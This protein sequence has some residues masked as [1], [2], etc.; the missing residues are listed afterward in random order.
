LFANLFTPKP[1]SVSSL[2]G[3]ISL[4]IF[5]LQLATVWIL[6][7]API[8]SWFKSGQEGATPS[9]DTH[10]KCPDCRELILKDAKKCKHCGC[11]LI[12]Q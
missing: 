10:V 5:M 11:D 3:F 1:S 8:S 2:V 7:S 6:L 12:P 4:P 9:P